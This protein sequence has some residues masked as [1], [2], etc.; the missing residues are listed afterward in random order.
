MEAQGSADRTGPRRQWGCITGGTGGC[1]APLHGPA[2][3]R[4]RACLWGQVPTSSTPIT[5]ERAARAGAKQSVSSF[6]AEGWDSAPIILTPNPRELVHETVQFVHFSDVI[7][8]PPT[9][10]LI[11]IKSHIC[12]RQSALEHV[13]NFQGG[14]RTGHIALSP[15]PTLRG[16]T[17]SLLPQ[18]RESSLQSLCISWS[19]VGGW[20]LQCT[21]VWFLSGKL[22]RQDPGWPGP[23]TEQEGEVASIQDGL[24][25]LSFGCIRSLEVLSFSRGPQGGPRNLSRKEMK[26]TTQSSR[27]WG[28]SQAIHWREVTTRITG[29]DSGKAHR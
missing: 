28:G 18:V 16:R 25:L 3:S 7:P 2:R 14:A 24:P 4:A 15:S 22:K 21:R 19:W 26:V 11:L 23:L 10:I 8:L 17:A 5:T 27:S 20:G 13:Q 6:L 12:S 1:T 9:H 29:D